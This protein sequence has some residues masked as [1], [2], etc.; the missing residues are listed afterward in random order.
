MKLASFALLLLPALAACTAETNAPSS[1]PTG[2]AQSRAT[3]SF[4]PT[5][6]FAK[7][8]PVGAGC[9][10]TNVAFSD[11]DLFS[12]QPV[13]AASPHGVSSIAVSFKR[14]VT[15]DVALDLT[16]GGPVGGATFENAAHASSPDDK[17]GVGVV[18]FAKPN[19][20]EKKL[21]KATVTMTDV[22]AKDGDVTSAHVVLDFEDGDVLDET[23][24]G[25]L[26]SYEGA[27]G[28]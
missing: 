28:G 6:V 8:M 10:E 16:L 26:V 21:S 20:P 24:S 27:C 2:T 7:R 23:F 22:P 17:T 11:A 9:G 4:S 13:N 18:V 14:T 19:T 25:S 15:K 3:F 5:D 1:E 12:L